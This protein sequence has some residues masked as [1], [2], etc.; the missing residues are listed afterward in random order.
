VNAGVLIRH[1][2]LIPQNFISCLRFILSA[3]DGSISVRLI[4]RFSFDDVSD[5]V[6]AVGFNAVQLPSSAFRSLSRLWLQSASV[7]SFIVGSP[8]QH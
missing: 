2:F 5:S 4:L 6:A 7:G 8:G 3:G 1:L